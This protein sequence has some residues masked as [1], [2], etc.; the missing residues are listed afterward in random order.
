MKWL[1]LFLI[2][3]INVAFSEIMSGRAFD[4]EGRFLFLEKHYI[5]RKEEQVVS[6]HSQYFNSQGE[7]IAEMSTNST[8][9]PYVPNVSFKKYS[10]GFESGSYIQEDSVVLYKKEPQRPYP[11]VKKMKCK[12]DMLLGHGLFFY[13]NSHFDDFSKGETKKF[14]YLLPNRLTSYQ[15]KLWGETHPKFSDIFVV[16]LKIDNWLLKSFVPQ[17][18]FYFNK[19]TKQLVTYEGFNGFLFEEDR[20]PKLIIEYTYE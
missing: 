11:K 8:N 7:M 18:R 16:H 6:V 1:S 15:F 19:E 14:S 12:G 9:Y 4:P 3:F 13:I 20:P 10:N 17:I 2:F 5:E